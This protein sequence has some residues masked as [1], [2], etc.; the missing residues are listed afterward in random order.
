MP[1]STPASVDIH[2]I[3]EPTGL[4][5]GFLSGKASRTNSKT[6]QQVVSASSASQG[7]SRAGTSGAGQRISGAVESQLQHNNSERSSKPAFTGSVLE[8]LA[9]SKGIAALDEPPVHA[10]QS[11]SGGPDTSTQGL[12]AASSSGQVADQAVPRKVSKF[13]QSR[14]AK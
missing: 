2:H 3:K 11:S 1:S 5:R 14:S 12:M 4:K 10:Q 9:L 8:R 13:K 7:T 6:S